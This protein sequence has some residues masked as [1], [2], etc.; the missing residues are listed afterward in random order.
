MSA[1][2]RWCCNVF[3][4]VAI[5]LGGL[6]A[7]H[8]GVS[9]VKDECNLKFALQIFLHRH[10]PV[11]HHYRTRSLGEFMRLYTGDGYKSRFDTDFLEVK[12]TS[13]NQ[14][15]AD[16][17]YQNFLRRD[18]PNG[19][20]DASSARFRP[21]LDGMSKMGM[22]ERLRRYHPKEHCVWN[23]HVGNTRKEAPA[24]SPEG[25]GVRECRSY[26]LTAQFRLVFMEHLILEAYINAS[27]V[28][29]VDHF[30]MY[31]DHRVLA[32]NTTF[33]PYSDA[34]VLEIHPLHAPHAPY[35]RVPNISTFWL[36]L[37]DADEYLV[38]PSG[39]LSMRDYLMPLTVWPR[40]GSRSVK[41][42]H[43]MY[44]QFGSSALEDKPPNVSDLTAFTQRDTHLAMNGKS[45][46]LYDAIDLEHSNTMPHELRLKDDFSQDTTSLLLNLGAVVAFQ[47]AGG[48]LQIRFKHL[49]AGQ[50]AVLGLCFVQIIVSLALYFILRRFCRCCARSS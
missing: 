10:M 16:R 15:V 30:V 32:I 13:A 26:F 3:F 39:F 24:F 31:A 37:I 14:S 9:C 20:Q 44:K 5:L 8:F 12:Q 49:A 1:I 23:Y 4:V 36:A 41:Q 2:L 47:D 7:F 18:T 48:R 11:V 28:L 40:D 27:T 46:A 33:A 6:L 43:C 50:E 22:A 45:V 25:Q 29:G 19:T 38:P 34:G 42:I 35:F 17:A 21:F